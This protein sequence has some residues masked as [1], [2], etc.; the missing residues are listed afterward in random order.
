MVAMEYRFFDSD[1]VVGHDL[2]STNKVSSRK[3]KNAFEKIR[4]RKTN[5]KNLF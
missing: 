1:G 3:A 2:H 5:K 4:K